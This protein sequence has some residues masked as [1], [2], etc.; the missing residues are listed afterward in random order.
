M[1]HSVFG[2]TLSDWRRAY[3]TQNQPNTLLT[4]LLEQLH[5]HSHDGVW[6]ELATPAQLQQQLDDLAVRADAHRLPLYGIPFAVKDNIDVAGFQTTAACPEYA[7]APTDDAEVV[8]L[9]RE[10]GA[11]VI[12]KTNLDQFATGL[13]GTRSPYGAVANPFHAD[14]ISGG[15]SSGSATAVALGYVPFALGTDTAGSGRIPAGFNHIVGLKPSK[16]LLST[17]GVVPACRSLDC[18]SIFS[19]HS[20]DADEVLRVTTQ[21]DEADPYARDAQAGQ[22]QPIKRLGIPS[23]MP[24]FGDEQQHVAWQEALAQAQQAGFECLEVDF[25]ACFELAA[26]LYQGPWVAERYA[27]VGGFIEQALPG[28]NPVVKAI[29]TANQAGQHGAAL[30]TA[31]DTFKA[32]YQRM[33]LVRRIQQMMSGVDALLVPTAPRFPTQADVATDPI[34]VNSQLGTYTNFVNL[35]DLSA[36]ALP[37]CARGDGLPFGVTVIASAFCEQALLQF[38]SRWQRQLALPTAP[39]QLGIQ[40]DD[41]V[42]V[43]VVGAHLTGMPLNHQLTSRHAV[44]LEQTVT[45]PCYQLYAL[46]NTTP[47][48][49]GLVRISDVSLDKGE[50]QGHTIIVELWRMS[51]K[52]FGSFVTEI[53]RPLGIG[54]LEL[55]D[56]REVKGFICE[57]EAVASATHISEFGGWRAYIAHRNAQSATA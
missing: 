13:V 45:A 11:I 31:V 26:L 3:T 32:E 39:Q 18:V 10:A 51:T 30:G 41:S 29:I 33:A 25:S 54:T 2:W 57:P 38:A 9:L 24:W 37:A 50:A 40:Q 43:A 56:G 16:G 8:R 48:K 12:G 28:I 52:A 1:T 17:R 20:D 47:P 15:S 49:P 36:I 7:Y 42:V 35:A 27:A 14:Y 44:L 21:F 6:I 19:L 4:S 46:A 34:G 53:P 22:A 23:Q 5:T 55:A